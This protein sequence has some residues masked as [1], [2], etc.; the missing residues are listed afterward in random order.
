MSQE[1]SRLAIAAHI[2]VLVRRKLGRVTDT[3][4]MACNL[5]YATEIIRVCR[6]E[7]D[8]DLASWADKLEAALDDLR[9]RRHAKPVEASPAAVAAPAAPAPTAEVSTWPD[10]VLASLQQ[11]V[12]AARQ[13]EQ[14]YVGR[15][16]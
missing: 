15:L 13:V 9:P 14:R 12:A 4:W 7:N 16:R 1:S 3:E 5:E 2:H 10:S 11:N 6:A 8:P